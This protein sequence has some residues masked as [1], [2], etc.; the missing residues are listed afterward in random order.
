MTD[1][2]DCFWGALRRDG[3][4]DG[5]LDRVR[6]THHWRKWNVRGTLFAASD[7]GVYLVGRETVQAGVEVT[8]RC[9]RCQRA[10]EAQ[11]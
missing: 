7:C 9:K 6:K 4:S 5:E 11:P 1:K 2:P 3:A 8:D 10:L